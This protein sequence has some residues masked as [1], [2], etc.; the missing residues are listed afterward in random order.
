MATVRTPLAG[1]ARGWTVT[2]EPDALI[3]TITVHCFT[4]PHVVRDVTPQ[5]A[6]DRMEAHYAER[7]SAL[8]QSTVTP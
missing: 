4:C 6:H 3:S 8:I 2:T 5:A 7:H 1:R